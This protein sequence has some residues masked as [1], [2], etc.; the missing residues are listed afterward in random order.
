[1]TIKRALVVSLG[2]MGG[3]VAAHAAGGVSASIGT[4]GVG[5]HL[6]APITPSLQARVGGNFFSYSRDGNTDDVEYEF[7]L[8]MR[9]LDALLDY[10]PMAGSFR[11]TGGVVYNG[12]R[13]DAVG[14]PQANG[15]YTIDGTTYSVTDVG[16]VNGEVKFRR[17]APYLGIGWGS[18]AAGPGWNFAADIGALFQGEPRTSLTSSGC[19]ASADLCAQFAEDLAA[20]NARLS[21]EV[22][23]FKVLPVIRIGVTYRF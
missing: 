15:T 10:Y 14:R 8:K 4:T 2:L 7:D 16:T 19:T 12:N 6:S 17:L 11:L 21:E 5:I 9:T 22:S 18:A 23:D 3:V 1:M 13:L 20:E